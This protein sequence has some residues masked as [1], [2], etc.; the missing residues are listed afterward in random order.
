MIYHFLTG[1]RRGEEYT[2]LLSRTGSQTGDVLLTMISQ[3]P[4]LV[5][6]HEFYTSF[7]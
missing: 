2:V 4:S 6:T 7:E 1:A 5:L 3:F